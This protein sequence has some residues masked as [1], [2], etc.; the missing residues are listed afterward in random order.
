MPESVK[1]LLLS[2][3]YLGFAPAVGFS[4]RSS[5]FA[6][7]VCFFLMLFTSVMIYRLVSTAPGFPQETFYRGHT[8][9]YEFTVMEVLAVILLFTGR[10][11]AQGR[12]PWIPPG[13]WFYMAYCV[14]GFC[15]IFSS[16]NPNFT[17]MAF[18]KFTKIL[19]VFVAAF[20]FFREEKDVHFFLRSAAWVLIVQAVVSLYYKYIV[21][22]YQVKA[23]FEHQNSMVM[24]TYM[25]G[26]PLLTAALSRLKNTRSTILYL[27]GYVSCGL[28][29]QAA[30]SRAGMLFFLI[31]TGIGVLLSLRDRFTPKRLAIIGVMFVIGSAGLAYSMKTIVGRFHDKVNEQ[32]K[33][34]RNMLNASSRHMLS[35]YPIFGTGWNTYGLMINP[36][37]PYG[38]NFDEDARSQGLKEYRDS[39]YGKP[40]SES[41]YYLIMAET[42]TMGILTLITFLLVTLFWSFRTVLR[43]RG[44]FRAAVAMGLFA[45]MGCNYLQSNY[46]RVLTQPKNMVAW[47]ICLGLVARLE[48]WRRQDRRL[49]KGVKRGSG[50]VPVRGFRPPPS[51]PRR[52]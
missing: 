10:G 15:S 17:M 47:M 48:W 28:S 6:Q 35:D 23:W 27:A 22:I 42:G 39:D 40:I 50:G 52:A 12:A 25:L 49:G 14:A 24:Y 43:C 30:L 21:N 34:V 4:I 33:N 32:S 8:R 5:R 13:F 37:Y 44:T 41:W 7:R 3:I 18:V 36:P 29:V 20:H 51:F 38:D 16:A 31:A 46:E 45:G 19:L 1:I 11:P 2:L 9:G 26:V